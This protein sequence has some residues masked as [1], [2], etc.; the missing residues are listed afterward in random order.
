MKVYEARTVCRAPRERIWALLT[1]APGYPA[2]NPTIARLEGRIALGEKLVLHVKASGRAFAL[3]VTALVPEQRMVW[4]GRAP[5][6]LFKG[7][8]TYTLAD[9]DGGIEVTMREV[10][11]GAM[12]GVITRA[13]PDLQPA[14]EQFVAALKR[15]A[16]QA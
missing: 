7:E 16:E 15:R 12:A 14:F 5:L 3:E 8:R 11:T 10:F 1:D 6:G 13:M 9:V 4:T 2:W